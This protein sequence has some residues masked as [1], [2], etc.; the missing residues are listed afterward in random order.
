LTINPTGQIPTLTE[1]D[2]L[3][4]GGYQVFV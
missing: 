2:F 3:V 4:L 1:S